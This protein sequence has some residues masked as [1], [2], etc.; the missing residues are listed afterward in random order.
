MGTA[1]RVSEVL[2]ESSAVKD[3]GEECKSAVKSERSGKVESREVMLKANPGLAE[4]KMR[5]WMRNV[6]AKW[7]LIFAICC[8]CCSSLFCSEERE[9]VCVFC[10]VSSFFVLRLESEKDMCER[11]R[12]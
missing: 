3:G 6:G 1:R 5:R 4:D 8:S 11:E 12:V 7:E 9:R 2:R 10:L